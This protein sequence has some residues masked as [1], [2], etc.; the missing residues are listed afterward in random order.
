MIAEGLYRPWAIVPMPDGRLLVTS[1]SGYMT[2][3]EANGTQTKKITGFPPVVAKGQGGML[4]VALDPDF[5]NN[6][7][8]YWSFSEA[9]G[10]ANLMAVAKGRISA[11]EMTVENPV[12]I[13]RAT[14]ALKSSL[15]FG[16]RLVFDKDGHLFVSTGERSI[17]EGRKQAQWLNSGL[18]KVFKITKEGKPAPGNPFLNTPDAMPEIYTYGNRNVQ[19]LDLH[20]VS[21]ELWGAEFGPRGGDELNLL[22]PGKNYGWPVPLPM[23]LNMAEVRLAMAFSKKRVWSNRCIIGIRYFLQ[24]VWLFMPVRIFPNGRITFLSE[25]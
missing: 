10:D 6:K 12:V 14:P 9:Q 3:H 2:I 8:I 11:D 23:A 13:F 22:K 7:I 19:S 5:S 17:A 15:H 20:P 1:I 16:S 21:G 4:D 25:V 24:A 18:G